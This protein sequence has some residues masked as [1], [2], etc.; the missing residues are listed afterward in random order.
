MPKNK[1]KNSSHS[2]KNSSMSFKENNTKVTIIDYDANKFKERE[3]KSIDECKW[4]K[5]TSTVT[6]IDTENTE[7]IKQL[8]A[9][10]GLHP[11]ILEDIKN[12][13]Q[14]PKLEDFGDYIYMLIKMLSYNQ[15]DG[16]VEVEQISLILGK[17][18]VISFQSGKK[19][20][21]FESVREKIRKSK[22]KIR[23]MGAD[24]LVYRI[25]DAVI[26]NCFTV[27]EYLGERIELLEEELVSN[28]STETIKRLHDLKR[29]VIV[30][31]RSVWP[32][33]EVIN[34]LER[35]DSSLIKKSTKIYLRDIYYNAVQVMDNIETTR[36]ILSEMI[37][38]YLSSMSN[39]LNEIMKVLTIIATIFMP[40][41][42][43]AGMY[44]MNFKFF[45]EIYWKY[46]YLFFWIIV[47]LIA[48]SMILYFKKKKWIS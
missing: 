27:L 3:A 14:R 16:T 35:G 18:F 12:T 47:I 30:L 44:G 39:K 21:A 46:G 24:Y 20:D 41:T 29:E 31:R 7:I 15:Q 2:S 25:I 37:D 13:N 4:F 38:I 42:F 10:F 6:W 40:L 17:N 33:R 8:D 1:S 32:L 5:N 19:G 23:K 9:C 11:L 36:D 45:P 28:P 48:S 34:S 22:G 43:V 26:D